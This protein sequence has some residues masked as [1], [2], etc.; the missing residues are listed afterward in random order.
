VEEAE[1]LAHLRQLGADRVQGF[2]CWRPMPAEQIEALFRQPP[3]FLD[4][5]PALPRAA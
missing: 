1:Q 3:S 5:D 2:Y 4:A